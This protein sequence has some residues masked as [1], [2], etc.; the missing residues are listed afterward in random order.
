MWNDQKTAFLDACQDAISD[1]FRAENAIHIIPAKST[2]AI[3]DFSVFVDTD[4]AGCHSLW[5]NQTDL[6]AVV[7]VGDSQGFSKP[8]RRMLAGGVS[9]IADLA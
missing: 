5:A 2:G 8:Y 6:D 3:F 4:Q 7:T 1:V 9:G